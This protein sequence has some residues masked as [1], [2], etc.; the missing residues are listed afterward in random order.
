MI[1]NNFYFIVNIVL[2]IHRKSSD[3]LLNNFNIIYKIN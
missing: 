2:R 3:G 1:N